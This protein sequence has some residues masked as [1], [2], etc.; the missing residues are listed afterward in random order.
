MNKKF[1]AFF[2]PSSLILPETPSL[3]AG[4]PPAA[5]NRFAIFSSLPQVY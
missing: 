4:L 2:H 1:L 5:R 3:A